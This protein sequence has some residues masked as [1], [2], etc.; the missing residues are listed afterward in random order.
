M[1]I[2]NLVEEYLDIVDENDNVIDKDTRENIWKRGLKH[3]VRVVNILIF[4]T[5]DKLLL[6]KRSMNRRIF[7][8]C[9]D[10]S[11]GEHVLT[12]E[13][14]YDAAIRGL[15]EELGIVD[16]KLIELGKLTPKEDVS[17]FMKVYQLTYDGEINNYDKNGIDNLFWYD[18]SAVKQMVGKDKSK[19]KGDFPIVLDWYIK[20][21][22][23]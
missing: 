22:R 11:C 21:F 2:E 19:F 7:P 3:N 14:Y 15:K 16:I 1:R 9:F 6:P 10:F 13:N 23:K 5:K 8:G 18:L 17:C 12:G 20:K 4:N